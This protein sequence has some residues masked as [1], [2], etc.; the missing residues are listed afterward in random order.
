MVVE[1]R[2]GGAIHSKKVA[3]HRW[4]EDG[5]RDNCTEYR[6]AGIEAKSNVVVTKHQKLEDLY[7]QL[8]TAGAS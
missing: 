2:D 6:R 8:G 4:K 1:C 7:N 5:N 3:Y